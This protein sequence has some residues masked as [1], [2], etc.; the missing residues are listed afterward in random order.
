MQSTIAL[1][2]ALVIVGASAEGPGRYPWAQQ[3]AKFLADSGYGD[4]LMESTDSSNT[5]SHEVIM[6]VLDM[7]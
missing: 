6:Q 7:R 2:F 5:T 1:F 3:I 4:P